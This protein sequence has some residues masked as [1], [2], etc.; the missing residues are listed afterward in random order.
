MQKRRKGEMSHLAA[1][2]GVKLD[3]EFD[4]PIGMLKD[5]HRKIKRSLHVLWV[6]ADRA[7]GRKLTAAETAAVRSAIDC[8]RVDGTRHT[9]DE[10][11]SLFPR[12]RAKTI[13][14][15][16]EELGLLEDNRH[17]ADSLHALVETLYSTWISAG[18]LRLEN[19]LQLQSSTAML[20]RLSEQHIQVE[21]QIVFP[22]A[23]RVLD[24]ETITAIAQEF[25]ARRNLSRLA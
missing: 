8:L 21:E 11:Q 25:R 18:A 14:G 17:Q 9:A 1:H 2:T 12:L 6:V 4:D 13:S 19:Q 22:R 5:C 16:S 20:K 15:D 24:G 23:Q 10:E 7:V 3:C